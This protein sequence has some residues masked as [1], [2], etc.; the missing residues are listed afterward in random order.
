MNDNKYK[1][2]IK[3]IKENYKQFKINIKPEILDEFKKKC[4][5]NNTTATTEIKKFINDYIENN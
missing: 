2:Q 3:H 5:K 4:E 1:Y